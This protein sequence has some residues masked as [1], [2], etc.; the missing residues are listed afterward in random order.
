MPFGACGRGNTFFGPS[1]ESVQVGF[2]VMRCTDPDP[3]GRAARRHR[4]LNHRR[5]VESGSVRGPLES[6]PT[7]LGHG[8]VPYR[9]SGT[10]WRSS[11]SGGSAGV[12]RAMS[13]STLAAP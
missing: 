3:V 12:Y 4:F 11:P 9:D 13:A 8:N 2:S 1:P 5:G 10:L 6:Q 7:I